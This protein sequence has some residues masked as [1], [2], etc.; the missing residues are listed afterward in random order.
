MPGY[1]SDWYIRPLP[2]FKYRSINVSC[3]LLSVIKEFR[4]EKYKY[5]I[6]NTDCTALNVH[7]NSETYYKHFIGKFENVND[8]AFPV[9]K[10][11]KRYRNRLP[12]LIIGLKESVKH[13]KQAF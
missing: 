12:W 6:L 10:V 4:I 11:K 7:E 1:Y 2:Y 9:I 3:Q 13:I 8:H 5:C